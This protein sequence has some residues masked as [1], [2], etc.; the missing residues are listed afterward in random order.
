MQRWLKTYPG[1][2]ATVNPQ[3]MRRILMRGWA[4]CNNAKIIFCLGC[5]FPIPLACFRRDPGK[6]GWLGVAKTLCPPHGLEARYP[7]S[8]PARAREAWG[9][10]RAVQGPGY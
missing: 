1:A 3:R 10:F 6:P 7:G 2:N 8:N 4:I 9:K 5:G